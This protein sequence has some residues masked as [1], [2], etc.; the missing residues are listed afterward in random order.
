[1]YE[2]ID[3]ILSHLVQNAVEVNPGEESCGHKGTSNSRVMS[4]RI[5]STLTINWQTFKVRL[6]RYRE[7]TIDLV[8]HTNLCMKCIYEDPVKWLSRDNLTSSKRATRAKLPI[9]IRLNTRNDSDA[10]AVCGLCDDAAW[11][12]KPA[13]AASSAAPTVTHPPR[14]TSQLPR[15]SN[16][17]FFSAR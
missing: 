13:Q 1:M 12:L 11:I 5:M 14:L 7:L 16:F 10:R 2:D 15:S 9:V 17:W 4:W 3:W 6:A 8:I